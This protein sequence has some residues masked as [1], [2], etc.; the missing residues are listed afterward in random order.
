MLA[1]FLPDQLSGWV[2]G[3]G[4]YL[5]KMIGEQLIISMEGVQ[6]S[7]AETGQAFGLTH[8]FTLS[9]YGLE[10]FKL[11]QNKHQTMLPGFVAGGD[12]GQLAPSL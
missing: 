10:L 6:G 5:K 12:L 1:L 4:D 3:W 7:R 8:F 11:K 9:H 2:D